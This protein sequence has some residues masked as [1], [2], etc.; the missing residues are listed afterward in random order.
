MRSG[1]RADIQRSDKSNAPDCCALGK[2]TKK[3]FD[4]LDRELWNV[5]RKAARPS[6]R[7]KEPPTNAI[8]I[9]AQGK[10]DEQPPY[11]IHAPEACVAPEAGP[12]EV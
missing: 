9:C 4:H 12:Q 6:E 1:T 3:F 2:D 10:N 5:E 11:C 7:F 8:R